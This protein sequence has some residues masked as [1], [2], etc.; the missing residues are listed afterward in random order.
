MDTSDGMAHW[1]QGQPKEIVM[2]NI[3]RAMF[4]GLVRI[5]GNPCHMT[6]VA[7]VYADPNDQTAK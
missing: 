2:K 4:A 1:Y 7:N 6:I 5:K 3:K